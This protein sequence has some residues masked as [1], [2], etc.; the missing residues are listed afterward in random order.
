MNWWDHNDRK[1]KMM[2]I[3]WAVLLIGSIS[4]PSGFFGGLAAGIWL[5]KGILEDIRAHRSGDLA[6]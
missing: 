6:E 1:D 4:I 5:R 2:H 3:V